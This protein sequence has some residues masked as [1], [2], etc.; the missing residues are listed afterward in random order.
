MRTDAPKRCRP[1]HALGLATHQAGVMLVECLVYLSCLFAVLGVATAVFFQ[2]LDFSRALRRNADDIARVLK[3]GERWRADIRAATGVPTVEERADGPALHI[4]QRGG[5]VNYLFVTNAV[6]RWVERTDHH[7][8]ILPAA[9]V[10]RFTLEPR[11]QVAAWRWELEL[12][13][14]LK[15]VRVHPLFCFT[16]VASREA[17]P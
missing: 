9:K 10:C 5:P 13:S 12:P 7:E 14:R 1:N 3:A 17:Q 15:A 6:V 11:R 4:P 2:V 8:I 16:A